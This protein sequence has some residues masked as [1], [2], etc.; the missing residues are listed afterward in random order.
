MQRGKCLTGLLAAI[1]LYSAS[2]CMAGLLSLNSDQGVQGAYRYC[3]YN[4]GKIY[5]F[6]AATPCPASFQEPIA[7]GKG[8]GY[9]KAESQE[10][11]SKLCIYRVSGQDRSIR[12]DTHANCPLNQE[13]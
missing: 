1:T 6:N 7:N 12:I 10:G 11:T 5:G 8:M 4:N 2:P 9:F 13:F 3:E